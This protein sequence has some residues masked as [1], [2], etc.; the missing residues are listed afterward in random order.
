MSTD[1]TACVLIVWSYYKSSIL[2]VFVKYHS[3]YLMFSVDNM[4]QQSVSLLFLNGYKTSHYLLSKW[5]LLPGHN[6]LSWS[7]HSDALSIKYSFF[8]CPLS[9]ISV[10]CKENWMSHLNGS[11]KKMFDICHDKIWL[12]NLFLVKK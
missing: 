3:L 10:A 5:S 9:R 4:F 7:R 12:F 8:H 11:L 6:L 1:G 2:L